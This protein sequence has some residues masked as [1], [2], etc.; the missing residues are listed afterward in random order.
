MTLNEL[1]DLLREGEILDDILA[2]EGKTA[3]ELL[4][5]KRTVA[6]PIDVLNMAL[7]EDFSQS[8][9]EGLW[10]MII[11]FSRGNY[12]YVS[13]EEIPDSL[14]NNL[15]H[16]IEARNYSYLFCHILENLSEE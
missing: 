7:D 4:K 5:E 3:K 1:K 9:I 6:I 15:R 12:E 13:A 2:L 11:N 14:R 16:F 8:Q 10:R